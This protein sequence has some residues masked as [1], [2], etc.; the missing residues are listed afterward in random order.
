MPFTAFATG[1]IWPTAIAGFIDFL[2]FL[3]GIYLIRS[4]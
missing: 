2:V 4:R 3:T 1:S